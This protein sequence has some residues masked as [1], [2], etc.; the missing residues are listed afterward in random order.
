MGQVLAS[1]TNYLTSLLT[2]Y[3]IVLARLRKSL[4]DISHVKD[5]IQVWLECLF[6]LHTA[7]LARTAGKLASESLFCV[8]KRSFI[9]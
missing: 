2:F 8:L 6:P 7:R 4:V 9:N 3:K 5:H 1:I